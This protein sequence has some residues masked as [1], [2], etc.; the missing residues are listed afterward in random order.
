MPALLDEEIQQR[1]AGWRRS[2]TWIM[3]RL[4]LQVIRHSVSELPKETAQALELEA[5]LR[6]AIRTNPAHDWSVAELAMLA[7]V[8]E[9]QLNRLLRQC[10]DCTALELISS[11]RME[12][13]QSLLLT[14]DKTVEAV[15]AAL[16]YLDK[17]YFSRLF[18]KYS[19][20]SPQQWRQ[21]AEQYRVEER[22]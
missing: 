4:L 3:Q 9:R 18:K 12:L 8:S 16:G 15:A 5:S 20:V 11:E 17:R 22:D 10:A 19:S 6:A 2:C 1:G 21:Q 14:E 13:A 7:G